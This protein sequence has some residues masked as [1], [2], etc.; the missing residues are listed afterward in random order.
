VP[1]TV[2]LPTLQYADLPARWGV[3]IEES[4]SAVR[5][6][7]QPTFGLGSVFAAYQK[8]AIVFFLLLALGLLTVVMQ[9][10]IEWSAVAANTMVYGMPLLI[11]AMIVRARLRCRTVFEVTPDHVTYAK[12]WPSGRGDTT[13]WP[14]QRIGYAKLNPYN[15]QMTLQIIG[16]NLLQIWVSPNREVTAFVADKLDEALRTVT[17]ESDTGVSSLPPLA[18]PP[19][20]LPRWLLLTMS[21]LMACTGIA[22]MVS[23]TAVF[24]LGVYLVLLAAF[25]IGIAFG[26]QPKKFWV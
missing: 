13:S 11:I 7:V 16:Q 26:T 19:R 1:E 4:P 21:A 20:S 6:S 24:P 2:T 3:S 5:I 25:P 14:R 23:D 10:Q 22:I 8:A 9:R 18:V 17:R 15:D 12:V